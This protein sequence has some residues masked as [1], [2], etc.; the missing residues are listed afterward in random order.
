MKNH[1]SIYSGQLNP[2]SGL[3]IS[4]GQGPGW[5]ARFLLEPPG[6][7]NPS[8]KTIAGVVALVVV[9]RLYREQFRLPLSTQIEMQRVVTHVLCVMVAT[10]AFVTYL[11]LPYRW[12]VAGGALVGVGAAFGV[13]AVAARLPDGTVPSNAHERVMAGWA[14]LA[15]AGL[16]LPEFAGIEESGLLVVNARWYVVGLS[17]VMAVYGGALIQRDR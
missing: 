9:Y 14:I 7:V 16:F 17:M 3:P 6:W 4:D 5:L 15:V 13:Q 1:G 12:D 8:L 11:D 2:T 10:L